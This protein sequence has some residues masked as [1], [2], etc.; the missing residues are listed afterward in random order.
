MNFIDFWQHIPSKVNST[1]FSIGN[2]PIK[3]YGLMYILAFTTTYLMML[4]RNKK[5]SFGFDK[6]LI[7]DFIFNEIIWVMI[8]GRLGYVLF[9]N[10]NYFISNPLEIFLPF[11]IVDGEF[12]LTGIAGMSYHGATIAAI[13]GTYFFS[14]RRKIN[15]WKMADFTVV[16]VPLGYTFGR[17]GNFTN[18]ELY[19]RATDFILGMYF[20]ASDDGLLRHPSQLYEAFFEGI[21]L[22]ILLWNLRNLKKIPSGGFIGLY[23]IGYGLFRFMIEYVREPDSH[24]G[25][26]SLGFSM[27]QWLCLCMIIIGIL[28]ILI[29][30]FITKQINVKGNV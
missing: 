15:F 16:L 9:Y 1:L 6:K 22:F 7:E 8:G 24:L 18:G 4:Y 21:V 29:R 27:G 10:L 12:I 17:I 2:F 26:L 5:D 20:P 28:L 14:R 23:L 13:L 25:L 11:K 30:S 3:Y 19:G